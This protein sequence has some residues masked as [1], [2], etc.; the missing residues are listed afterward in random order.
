MDAGALPGSD[1]VNIEP[2]EGYDTHSRF[3]LARCGP[4]ANDCLVR[5]ADVLRWLMAKPRDLPFASALEEVCTRIDEASIAHVYQVN[6]MDYAKAVAVDSPWNRF[7]DHDEEQDWTY[8]KRSALNCVRRMRGEWLGDKYW[9]AKVLNDSEHA[10][11]EYDPFTESLFDYWERKGSGGAGAYAIRIT[12][13]NALWGWGKVAQTDVEA[14][15]H[16]GSA[17]AAAI[18]EA[19]V[20]DWPSL[21]QYRLVSARLVGSEIQKRP[22]WSPEH[23]A[24]L[25]AKLNQECQAGRGRG[26]VERLA[27]ELGTSRQALVGSQKPGGKPGPLVRYGYSVTTGLKLATPFDGLGVSKKEA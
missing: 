1:E 4:A 8:E 7:F 14:L 9:M 16:V 22:A 23:T 6:A 19:D 18:T 26:A 10:P 5:L 3:G 20:T 17:P 27:K 13:A 25:A 2:E 12:A 24:I 21:V 11:H 15:G